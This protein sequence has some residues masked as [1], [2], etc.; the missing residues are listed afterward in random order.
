[1]VGKNAKHH[2]RE[3]SDS[4]HSSKLSVQDTPVEGVMTGSCSQVRLSS[5]EFITIRL[6]QISVYVEKTRLRLCLKLYKQDAL[7]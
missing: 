5:L 3:I 6:D 2:F 1:M 7:G 4:T